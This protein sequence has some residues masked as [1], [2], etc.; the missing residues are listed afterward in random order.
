MSR[1]ALQRLQYADI[2]PLAELPA[3]K[4]RLPHTGQ[5]IFM[6]VSNSKPPYQLISVAMLATKLIMLAIIATVIRIR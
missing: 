5:Q 6:S 1:S 3:S 4:S 2:I